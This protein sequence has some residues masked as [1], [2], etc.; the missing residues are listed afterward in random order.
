MSAVPTVPNV[1]S[2]AV[3][4]KHGVSAQRVSIISTNDSEV[5]LP[6]NV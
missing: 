4:Y 6:R 5:D 3:N 2:F 1:L